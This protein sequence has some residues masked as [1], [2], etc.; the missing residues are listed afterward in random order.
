MNQI[1]SM[2]Q[3]Q[4]SGQKLPKQKKPKKEK[5]INY[6]RPSDKA[7]I[8]SIV[9]VFCVLIILFGLVLVGDA[10]YGIMNS[11]PKLRDNVNVT[12]NAIGSN[13]TINAVGS[14]PIQSLTYRWNQGEE[15]VVQGNGT[16]ELEAVVQIPTGNNILNM[17]V[18]DYYGNK[19]EFQK[20]YINEQDDSSKPTIEISVSGNML[21]ITATDETEMSYLTYSWNNGTPTRVDM[22]TT[23]TDKTV[24]RTSVEVQK[25]ENTLSIVAV[26]I[27]GNTNTRTEKI[28]GANKPT[29]T[30]NADGTN[31][32][33]KAQDEDGI[34]K[35]E[36]TVD[37]ITSDTGDEPL[38]LKEL[39]ATQAI[40]PGEHTVTITVT[41]INGLSE[42]QSFTVTL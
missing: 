8:V 28:K 19:S 5:Q 12:A 30:V 42:E 17:S 23:L 29:F 36:I 41:N 3:S 9:R 21:N 26:D 4:M 20:Q 27:D 25:G 15:T 16:V 2:Q 38:N 13:V 10:T 24:L 11:R 22:D 39:T 7:N 34:S 1:L 37:G 40:T 32:V 35:V 33:I 6:G 31:L 14:M 18:I